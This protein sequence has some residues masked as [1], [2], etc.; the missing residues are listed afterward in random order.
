VH[1]RLNNLAVEDRKVT[2]SQPTRR[3]SSSSNG[4]LSSLDEPLDPSNPS[5]VDLRHLVHQLLDP[6]H[7]ALG[8]TSKHGYT[9]ASPGSLY[10]A[11]EKGRQVR[12]AG[13]GHDWHQ[14]RGFRERVEVVVQGLRGIDASDRLRGGAG[15]ADGKVEVWKGVRG[16]I[17]KRLERWEKMGEEFY[18]G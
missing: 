17:E 1:Q 10:Q 13:I 11:S 3:P 12:S 16:D 9:S 6:I 8:S 14:T 2:R 15:E 5:R 7:Q 4:R 18:G